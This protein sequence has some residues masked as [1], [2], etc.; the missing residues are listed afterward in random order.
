MF[1]IGSMAIECGGS[2]SQ[3]GCTEE[4]PAEFKT[5]MPGARTYLFSLGRHS[6]TKSSASDANVCRGRPV[7]LQVSPSRVDQPG[8]LLLS[9]CDPHLGWVAS[10]KCPSLLHFGRMTLFSF[11]QYRGQSVDQCSSPVNSPFQEVWILP[12]FRE[13]GGTYIELFRQVWE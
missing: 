8:D 9:R 6:T 11:C 3:A 10:P 4:W 7:V 2:G 1:R 13:L 12:R 5:A